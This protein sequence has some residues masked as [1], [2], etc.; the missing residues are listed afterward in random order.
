M[1]V[2]NIAMGII[3]CIEAVLLRL[4]ADAWSRKPVSIATQGLLSFSVD[5]REPV[6][7]AAQHGIAH[8]VREQRLA[9]SA[10][11][12]QQA[13]SFLKATLAKAA[14]G[15]TTAQRALT[16]MHA[17]LPLLPAELVEAAVA[18]TVAS[19]RSGNKAQVVVRRSVVVCRDLHD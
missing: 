2:P 19:Y 4:P 8:L 3:Q 13:V 1:A 6:S 5:S 17:L 12:S 11:V 14:A 9:G 10:A 16:L 15:S 7:R 18:A